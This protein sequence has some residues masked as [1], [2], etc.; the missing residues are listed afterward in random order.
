MKGSK[1]QSQN[2]W[3]ECRNF[4]DCFQ[5]VQAKFRDCFRTVRVK[6]L[7]LFSGSLELGSGLVLIPGPMSSSF[8]VCF[9]ITII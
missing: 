2:F 1:F 3:T 5:T 9:G 6:I 7:G 4:W 8:L